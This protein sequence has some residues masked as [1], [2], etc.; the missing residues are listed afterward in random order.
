ML[1]LYVWWASARQKTSCDLNRQMQDL[2]RESIRVQTESNELMRELIAAL[3][4]G[5]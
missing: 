2:A 4:Q 1:G 3:R 5:R